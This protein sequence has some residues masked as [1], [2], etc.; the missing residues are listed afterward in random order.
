M[1]VIPVV[2]DLALQRGKCNRETQ[3]VE[4]KAGSSIG[5]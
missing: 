4:A 1:T 5:K 3:R 2:K